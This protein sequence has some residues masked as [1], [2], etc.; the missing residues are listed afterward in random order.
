MKKTKCLWDKF[1]KYLSY[2]VPKIIVTLLTECGYDNALS[3]EQIQEKELEEIED[4]VSENLL[5][6]L[7]GT[8]YARVYDKQSNQFKFLS[9]HRVLIINLSKK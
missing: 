5:R 6:A 3:V 9:D 4:L 7:Q 8:V 1:N 2:D